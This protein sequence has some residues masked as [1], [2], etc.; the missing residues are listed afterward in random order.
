MV[1]NKGL[2]WLVR[3]YVKWLLRVGYGGF[4]VLL[5]RGI[6]ILVF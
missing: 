4:V 3:G 5:R 2:V 1:L 6:V